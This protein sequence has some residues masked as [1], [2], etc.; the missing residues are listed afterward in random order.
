M[1]KWKSFYYFWGHSGV[2]LASLGSTKNCPENC[3][4]TNRA[5]RKLFQ[6]NSRGNTLKVKYEFSAWQIWFKKTV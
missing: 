2:I 5:N 6:L 3:T 4:N 1:E